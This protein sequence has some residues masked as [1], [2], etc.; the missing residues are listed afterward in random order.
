M[1]FGQPSASAAT[2]NRSCKCR[3]SAPASV[4][5]PTG[6]RRSDTSSSAR[7]NRCISSPAHLKP[8]RSVSC[9]SVQPRSASSSA[10]RSTRPGR[11]NAAPSQVGT[12]RPSSRTDRAVLMCPS[13]MYAGG[14]ESVGSVAA[15]ARVAGLNVHSTSSPGRTSQRWMSEIRTGVS[16]RR[17][18][19]ID[20]GSAV[21]ASG[22]RRVAGFS[23][24]CVTSRTAKRS[25]DGDR[26]VGADEA[27]VGDH[28]RE[29]VLSVVR[30]GTG[31]R[32]PGGWARPPGLLLR[33]P[34][35]NRPHTY[36]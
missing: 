15:A 27:E 21:R 8:L 31:E 33:A 17:R 23:A 12:N 24:E 1:R 35:A 20:Q 34:P 14:R 32:P 25:V 29:F 10:S 2:S 19:R 28:I 6:S 9:R 7:V 18:H 13:W 22:G 11:S 36:W 26:V 3:T 4:K 5:S 16:V 30:G